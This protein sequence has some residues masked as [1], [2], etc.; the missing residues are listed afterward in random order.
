MEKCEFEYEGRKCECTDL[1]GV[2]RCRSLCKTHFETV[3]GD[4]IRRFN[5]NQDIPEELVFTRK[6][7]LSETW[8]RFGGILK[9]D[10]LCVEDVA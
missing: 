10:T 4:N 1:V 8:S 7:R 6:L 9:E 2:A 5:K 3:R